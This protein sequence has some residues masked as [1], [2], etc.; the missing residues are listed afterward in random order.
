[1]QRHARSAR[2]FVL[3]ASLATLAAAGPLVPT[4]RAVQADEV[5]KDPVLEARARTISAELRCLVCQNQSIDDSDAPLARDLRLLVREKLTQG[6]SDD[7]VIAFLV[8]RYGE[9]VLLRPSFSWHNALLWGGPF[10]ILLAGGAVV[11]ASARK[12]R[13]RSAPAA[14]SPSERLAL[15][16]VLSSRGEH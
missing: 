14:L 2:R 6:A 8:D 13:P 1:M 12:R 3:A 10:A 11:W 7:Q 9:F 15:D 5:L 16:D 4:A